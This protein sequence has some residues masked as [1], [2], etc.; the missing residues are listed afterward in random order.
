MRTDI[1]FYGKLPS[2]GD[3]LRRRVSDGFVDAWDRWL[4]SCLVASRESL[5]AQWLEVFLTSPVWRFVC[6]AGASGPDT[7]LG[8]M[9]PSVDRAARYFP[10]TVVG[11]VP[12]HVDPLTAFM[13][14]DAFFD[15]AQV[16]LVDT[17]A[18]D[19]IDFSTFDQTVGELASRLP[20][21]TTV[22]HG[23]DPEVAASVL[24]GGQEP[25]HLPIA[26]LE[27]AEAAFRH[28]LGT[29]LSAAHAPLTIWGTDGSTIVAP[30]CLMASGLPR[31]DLFAAMLNGSWA[32]GGWRS[33]G[34]TDGVAASPDPSDTLTGETAFVSFR[35][36]ALSDV[37]CK[38]RI[39]QDSFIERSTAGLWAVA[40]GLG[41]HSRGEEASRMLC[42]AL[43]DLEPSGTFEE[44]IVAAGQRVSRVNDHLCRASEAEDEVSASTIVILL[45]RGE[46]F[47]V[48]WAGD[49]RA[50]LWREGALTRLTRD[51]SIAELDDS[52][53]SDSHVVTRAVGVE[54][55]LEIDV[56]RD[57]LR[58]GDRFLLCSDGLTHTLPDD[59]IATMMGK[60]DVQ[61]VA[62]DLIQATLAAG[63]PDNVTIIVTEA[64][65]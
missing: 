5:A 31:A 27:S 58:V 59:E 38:R 26:K 32:D 14:A 4:Q 8:V 41:G 52:P 47:A 39:N 53:D 60:P 50:Y 21:W 54:R 44:M 33:I 30:G 22:T 29:R 6:A 65:P 7:V 10:L 49:S 64:S 34:I 18:E 15:A 46:R 48:L 12:A 16:L 23:L 28:M 20:D 63:A 19:V 13:S 1:G 45:A 2:H 36:A 11:T 40:D 3:F 24:S 37:G 9:V 57:Q 25:W 43:A 62:N 61:A 51:H 35:S 56:R 17:L 42:D 55:T